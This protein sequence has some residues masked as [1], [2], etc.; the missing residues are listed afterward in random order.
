MLGMR[1]ES[2]A[3]L[4]VLLLASVFPIRMTLE[5]FYN[6]QSLIIFIC[7]RQLINLLL[8]VVVRIKMT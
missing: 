3:L 8:R 5:T 4:L 7:N 1:R 2:V 6:P